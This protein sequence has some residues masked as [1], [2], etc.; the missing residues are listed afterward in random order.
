MLVN[1]VI[2]LKKR[3]EAAVAFFDDRVKT[4]TASLDRKITGRTG[5]LN[6]TLT[7]QQSRIASLEEEVRE[8]KL[9]IAEYVRKILHYQSNARQIVT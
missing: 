6:A 9:V 8:M 3:I 5:S 2:S 1:D 7:R 4:T